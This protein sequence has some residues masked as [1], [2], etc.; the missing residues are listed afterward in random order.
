MG[1]TD[2][3]VMKIRELILDG[4]LKAGDRLPHEQEL[5][6]TLGLSRSSMREAVRALVHARVLDVRQGS[7]TFV[8]SLRPELLLTG[9][10]FAVEML[11]DDTLLEVVEV[12]QL[13]EPAA[14]RLAAMRMT[15]ERLAAIVAAHEAHSSGSSVERLVECDLAF[16]RA[17][18][19]AA[20]NST[21]LSILDGLSSQTV[22]LRTWGGV[23][24]DGAVSKTIAMHQDIVD[25]L[26]AG[27]PVLAEASALTHVAHA[28]R[29]I[30]AYRSEDARPPD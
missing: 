2:E 18:V 23:V 5:A 19:Q 20:G 12:R 10:G 29:W 21:L 26:A 9:L 7:G 17:I 8:T 11:R 22:R 4:T 6:S 3:A 14:T 25:A 27:D 28:R 24:S 1:V 16:H 13:L 30:D 15:P